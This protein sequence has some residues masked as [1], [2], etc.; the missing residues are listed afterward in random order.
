MLYYLSLLTHTDQ[1]AFFRL[2][3]YLTF[4]AGAS[5]LTALMIA[6]LINPMLIRWLKVKQGKGQ[7][8]RTDGPQR[9]I[10]EKAGTPTMGGL[11][12]L[13]PWVGST[14]L[15]ASLSNRYVWIALMVTTTYGMLGFL[16]DYYKVTKRTSDGLS[17]R[18]RLMIEFVVA[19]LGTWLI[20]QSHTDALS[21]ALAVPFI[22]TALIPLGAFFVVVGVFVIAGAANAVNF[23]DGLDGLAI[24]PVMI[25]A[26]TFTLIVYLV[27]NERFSAYL[28]IPY[29][30][31]S[32]ELAVFLAALVGAGLGFLWYNAPPAAIFMGD[33]GSLP[34]GGALGVVAVAVK[35]EIVLGVVGGLFVLET[36][37]VVVQVIS[38]KL[39]GKRVF[40]MAP[41]HHHYE[42]LGWTEPTIVIRFWIVA[43]VLALLGLATLKIR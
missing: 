35:H 31:Y 11:L 28:Q 30:E 9:H 16:D 25:A 12:I 7:P 27:G 43:V 18:S 5:V 21:G 8:I 10:I 32:G 36:V 40:K 24:V 39:T 13:I 20:M 33:T 37:S 29:V 4:R 3:R 19:A 1:L 42:Q 22:K 34:L 38:F 15:W 17:G 6:F 23:T 14:L 2:F 41:I 26:A